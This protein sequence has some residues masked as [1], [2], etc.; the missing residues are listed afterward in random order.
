MGKSDARAEKPAS[1]PH[2][3]EDL[4]ATMY[5]LLGI[6]PNDEFI[7]PDG[8]PVRIVNNGQVIQELL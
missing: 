8:R 5:T 2:G 3:P 1:D 4:A 7:T 6:D